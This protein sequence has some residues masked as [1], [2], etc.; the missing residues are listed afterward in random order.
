M[1]KLSLSI[2][3]SISV[4]ILPNS[5]A[6]LDDQLVL[7]L[8][9]DEG[10]DQTAKDASKHKNNG[11]LH[12]AGWDKGKYGNAVKLTGDKGGWVEVP[13]SASLDITDEITIA[14]WVY[15]TKFTNEWNRIVVKTWKGDT[16][17]W[18]VYGT[19]Q[20]GD[21]NGKTGF[22]ASVDKGTALSGTTD[23][24][25]KVDTWTHMAA[26]YDGKAVKIYYNG[27]LKM[28]A[29]GSGKMDTN[30]VPVSIG[31]NSEGNREHYAGLIDEV[32]IWNKAL[33]PAQ[34]KEA[35]ESVLNSKT[36][37][38]EFKNKLPTHWGQIKGGYIEKE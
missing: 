25:L 15:P 6:V 27:E 30:D 32:A 20:V 29:K 33:T 37:Q 24:Q 22:I 10:K 3:L 28:E 7:Y 13:D 5:F 12:E 2:M 34:I 36:T 17:P 23:E 26:T 4:M 31:R 9:F 19:Y 1:K 18:M 8:S 38:V 35:M 16:A 14:H 21:G 11:T